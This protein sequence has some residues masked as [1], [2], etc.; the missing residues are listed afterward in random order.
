ME[1]FL[2]AERLKYEPQ[3]RAYAQMLQSISSV[4][5]LRIGLYYPMLPKL[6]W[7]RA[8]PDEIETTDGTK[9]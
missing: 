9:S 3:M 5:K 8:D 2:A 4:E 1:E 7:W 6:I